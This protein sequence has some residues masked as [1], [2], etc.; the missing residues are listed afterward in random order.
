[1][2]L[3]RGNLWQGF[4]LPCL[5]VVPRF[6]EDRLLPFRQHRSAGFPDLFS[7]PRRL[8]QV[9]DDAVIFTESR[10]GGPDGRSFPDRR[11]RQDDPL[12]QMRG[13]Q[14]EGPH[15]NRRR[16]DGQGRVGRFQRGRRPVLRHSFLET[17]R[18]GPFRPEGAPDP[19]HPRPVRRFPRGRFQ[20]P[21]LS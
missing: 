4:P 12:P 14:S 11:L 6:Q 18:Q 19:E 13:Q 16:G 7:L 2:G 21:G 9:R 8:R 10:V 5:L 15:G 3:L 17:R 20:V 1:M